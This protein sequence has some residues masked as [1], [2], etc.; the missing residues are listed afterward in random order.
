MNQHFVLFDT[1]IQPSVLLAAFTALFQIIQNVLTHSK[2]VVLNT[3]PTTLQLDNFDVQ[4]MKNN[5]LNLAVTDGANLVTFQGDR[6]CQRYP[7]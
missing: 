6:C 2:V 4:D 1:D 7:S 3:V 5:T